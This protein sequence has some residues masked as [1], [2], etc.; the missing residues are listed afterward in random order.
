MMMMW[1]WW[2]WGWWQWWRWWWRWNPPFTSSHSSRSSFSSVCHAFTHAWTPAPPEIEA[3]A[4]NHSTRVWWCCLFTISLVPANNRSA[5]SSH[6]SFFLSLSLF[7][8]VYFGLGRMFLRETVIVCNYRAGF[9]W[10]RCTSINITSHHIW[11]MRRGVGKLLFISE[12]CSVV[13][14]H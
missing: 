1:W 13:R 6:L 5:A 7:L 11:P 8:R 12:L 3:V 9:R 2:W 10:W 14:W 4:A